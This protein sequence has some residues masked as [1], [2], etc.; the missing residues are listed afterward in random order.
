MDLNQVWTK[1]PHPHKSKGDD[2]Y[3]FYIT[4]NRV[5]TYWQ[6]HVSSSHTEIRKL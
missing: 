3:K 4:S 6:P 5:D 2:T 1:S